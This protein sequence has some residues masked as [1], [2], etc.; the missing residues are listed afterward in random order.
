MRSTMVDKAG[1][2]HVVDQVVR[3]RRRVG[4]PP[5]PETADWVMSADGVIDAPPECADDAGADE[6]PGHTAP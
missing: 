4:G 2:R 6:Q 3:R 5:A 1:L